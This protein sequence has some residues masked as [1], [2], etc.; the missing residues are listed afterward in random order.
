MLLVLES[1]RVEARPAEALGDVGERPIQLLL[2]LD[3]GMA[4][5]LPR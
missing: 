1:D 5:A 4:E 2:D 3:V